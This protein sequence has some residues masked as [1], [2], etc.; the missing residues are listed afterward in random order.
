MI[1]DRLS[2]KFAASCK[3]LWGYS[4]DFTMANNVSNQADV[5]KRFTQLITD[6]NEAVKE[7]NEVQ[8]KIRQQEEAN[9]NVSKQANLLRLKTEVLVHK[10]AIEEGKNHLNDK[11]VIALKHA[12]M[13][14]LGITN[15]SKG[16]HLKRLVSSTS[17]ED[18][19]DSISGDD[20]DVE[21]M[22]LLFDI[23]GVTSKLNE[24]LRPENGNSSS[25]KMIEWFTSSD[26]TISTVID[27]EKFV[28]IICENAK[29]LK[30]RDAEVM[31]EEF[32]FWTTAK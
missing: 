18:E 20:A 29:S 9:S 7:L 8:N 1:D 17:D 5:E 32:F 19:K 26:G 2:H 4:K 22:T 13:S 6:K 3:A 23:A 21:S 27:P 31:L 12:L 24:E 10:L 11:K 15:L 30:K 16:D 14:N 25:T 28:K